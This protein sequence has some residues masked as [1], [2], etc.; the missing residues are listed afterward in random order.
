MSTFMNRFSW[1]NIDES[2]LITR[3]SQK[4]T[5]IE[6]YTKA[7]S[8]EKKYA[9]WD[10]YFCE[11][12]GNAAVISVDLNLS[13]GAPHSCAGFMVY[14]S[15]KVLKKSIEGFPMPSELSHLCKIEDQV[16][17]A[18]EV[19]DN[20]LFCGR[21]TTN[22][23]RDLIF[24]VENPLKTLHLIEK[25]MKNYPEYRYDK[26]WKEDK[27]WDLYFSFLFPNEKELNTIFNQRVIAQLEQ[28]GTLLSEKRKI[29]H[30]AF[31]NNEEERDNFI[32]NAID[33]LFKI[34]SVVRDTTKTQ[35][36]WS[37]KISRYDL[38]DIENIYFCIT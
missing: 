8:A 13:E 5:M 33:D 28:N 18:L 19:L 7:K 36:C 14:A 10:F 6:H 38:L 21:V 20:T 32:L 26:G 11:V 22:G 30:T 34:E 3:M 9:D 23:C 25:V 27:E 24:Y 2:L 31:F 4:L 1:R 17:T 12:D 37:V 35:L 16:L 15:L 29:T